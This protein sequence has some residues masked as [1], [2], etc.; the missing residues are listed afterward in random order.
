MTIN[1]LYTEVTEDLNGNNDANSNLTPFVIDA[2]NVNINQDID[3]D[4]N[5][6]TD[7]EILSVNPNPTN[8]NL[9]NSA[10]IPLPD[11]GGCD[12]EVPNV[13]EMILN[14]NEIHIGGEN[15]QNESRV[16]VRDSENEREDHEQKIEFGRDT[17]TNNN[18]DSDSSDDILIAAG[19]K[20]V[21]SNSFMQNKDSFKEDIRQKKKDDLRKFMDP[22]DS[23]TGKGNKDENE[24]ES[25]DEQEMRVLNANKKS[26]NEVC[27]LT[28][29][30]MEHPI[31]NMLCTHWY[32]KE[33]I[34]NYKEYMIKQNKP[35]K[36]PQGGC[37]AFLFI[38]C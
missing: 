32:E 13:P 34:K 26:K 7:I 17:V 27:P 21:D 28:L 12:D 19:D 10:L 35:R 33:A 3:N 14:V 36:C 29:K 1:P 20:W 16:I 8:I 31:K 15:E 30:K 4:D 9:S 25:D 22:T 24:S 37:T 6:D 38:S 2:G 23:G 18:D 5:T 11:P